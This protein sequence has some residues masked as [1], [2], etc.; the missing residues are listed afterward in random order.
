MH[1]A[2]RIGIMGFG[3]VGRHLYRLALGN[4]HIEVVA[5]CDIA[6]PAVLH[7]LL[8]NDRHHKCDVALEGNY[9]TNRHYRSRIMRGRHPASVPWDIFDV[10]FVVDA[11]GRFNS[12]A[13]LQGH[14]DSG[15]T[16]VMTSI[17]PSEPLDRLILPGLND[18]EAAAADRII[19]AGSSTTNA[20]ALVL[21]ILDDTLGVAAASMVTLHAYTSDQSLQDYAGV[22]FRRSRSG[23]ENIIPNT[24]TSAQWVAQVL[25]KFTHCL[26][27][28]AL[29]VPLQKGSLM[30]LTLIMEDSQHDVEAVNE[31][32]IA[33]ADQYP[34]LLGLAHDPIVS[35][36]VIGNRH[37]AVYDLQGTIKAG[38]RMIKTLSWYDNGLSHAC[39]L[40]DALNLYGR[41]APAVA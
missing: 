41:L 36:D 4:E 8:T 20:L 16:R 28:N 39:R 34:S 23:A 18:A 26:Q 40:M 6:T 35:S 1:K 10:D 22:D 21:K 27:S 29:N 24:N 15:A 37:S 5:I 32:M 2:M 17:L 7:Y 19:S 30:D 25:P 12:R 9:L 38:S 13:E 14:L 3:H 31:A 33:G 11:T